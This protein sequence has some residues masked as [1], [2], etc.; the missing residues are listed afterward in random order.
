MPLIQTPGPGRKLQ[1]GLRL[2]S[3][4]D[5]VLAPEMVGVI[6]VEDFSAPL[7]DIER[8]CHGAVNR[9]AVAAENSLI[10]LVRVGAPAEYD[11]KVTK[12]FFSVQTT[13]I[14]HVRVPTAGLTGL[15]V[16]A[17]STFTEQSLNGRPSSQLA[18]N[19]QVGIPAGRDVF[20]GRV[21]LDTVIQLDVEIRIGTIGRGDDLTSIIIA[22]DSVNT[23]LTGG[24]VWTESDPQ[25]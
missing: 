22:A 1:R 20:L 6:I 23:G 11:L 14:V 2:T 24:F 15:T 21:M 10:A 3:L 5:S 19:T 12:I 18:S 7:T 17:N 13:Q 25:G 9:S 16:S 8:G 4:P